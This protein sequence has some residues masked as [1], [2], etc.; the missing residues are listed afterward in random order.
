MTTASCTVGQTSELCPL[1][2]HQNLSDPESGRIGVSKARAFH[3]LRRRCRGRG[4]R[5]CVFDAGG[6]ESAD[7]HFVL[8]T[9]NQA[10]AGFP[11]TPSPTSC[12]VEAVHH[13]R[14]V[15]VEF[16]LSRLDLAISL[17]G[18][19]HLLYP[20][21]DIFSPRIRLLRVTTC[22]QSCFFVFVV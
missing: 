13:E 22:C 16:L 7:L 1:H 15:V 12:S 11:A 6:S 20:S 17:E 18:S 19:V 21:K 4:P 8:V 14:L 3:S 10:S 5:R 2:C 9:V